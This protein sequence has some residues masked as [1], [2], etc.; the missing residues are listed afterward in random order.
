MNKDQLESKLDDVIQNMK[1]ARD[2]ISLGRFEAA[3]IV[4]DEAMDWLDGVL[5]AL[6]Q[7]HAPGAPFQR[8]REGEV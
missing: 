2:E 8:I 6:D 3:A 4:V 5:Q 1:Y 7:E